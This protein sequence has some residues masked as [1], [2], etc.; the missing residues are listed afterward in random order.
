MSIFS[1]VWLT[2]GTFEQMRLRLEM[3]S[4]K[5]DIKLLYKE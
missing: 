4:A 3:L 2:E 5:V 1:L